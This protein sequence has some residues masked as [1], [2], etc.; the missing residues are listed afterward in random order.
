MSPDTTGPS[1]AEVA[2]PSAPHLTSGAPHPSHLLH[3]Y[4][5]PG[6]EPLKP[7]Q[8][9]RPASRPH[10]KAATLLL[11]IGLIAIGLNL[12]IAVAAVGPVIANIRQSLGISS[13]A[14]SLLTTIPVFAFG[15]FAFIAPTLNRRIG[16]HRLL[17]LALFTLSAGIGL[18]LIPSMTFLLIGTVLVGAAIA[19]GNVVMPAAIKRDFSHRSGLMMG[20]YSTALFAGAAAASGLTAPLIPTLGGSWRAALGIWAIPALITL[21]LWVPQLLRSPGLA[22]PATH[23]THLVADAPTETGEVPFHAI[24]THPVALAV[25]AMMGMLSLNYYAILTWAPTLLTDSG[26]DPATAGGLVAYSAFP[27]I[28]ASL[29]SPAIAARTRPHWVPG[30]AAVV[31]VLAGYVG[32]G[33]WGATGSLTWMTLLGLGQGASI[34][35][36]L[37]YI[38]WRSPDSHHTGHLSTMAQGFGYIV[39]GIGPLG[40]GWLHEISHGWTV[41]LAA[42]AALMLIQLIAGIVA[43]RPVHI[44]TKI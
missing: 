5:I 39:A 30:T 23:A 14:A 43:S 21:I 22:R 3:D 19:I 35:L 11:A 34:S 13:S 36:G 38:V 6:G 16:M 7:S 29:V 44:H 9:L 20:L 8:V 10:S 18:R 40:I 4:P 28:V 17:G 1:H 12:R 15:L 37:T 26:M 41:P 42:L 25:T 31:L 24:L 2:A 32:L 33:I 27:G